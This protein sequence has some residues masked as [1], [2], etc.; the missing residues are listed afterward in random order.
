MAAHPA[1]GRG[2]VLS[3]SLALSSSVVSPPRAHAES[4]KSIYQVDP[5]VDGAVIGA[6]LALT[7]S[8]YIFGA[9]AIDARC[10]CDRNEVNAFDRHAIGNHSEVAARLSDVTVGLSLLAPAALD[11]LALRELKPYLEDMT[12]YAEALAV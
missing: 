5:I 12:V 11:W 4:E 7:I 6:S 1:I 8:L 10:P 3:L 2:L 9:G